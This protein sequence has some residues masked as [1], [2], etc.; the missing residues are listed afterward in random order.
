MVVDVAGLTAQN[1]HLFDYQELGLG[2]NF[3]W[4]QI[5]LVLINPDS[6]DRV[7]LSSDQMSAEI[8]V[9]DSGPIVERYIV[10]PEDEVIMETYGQ[11]QEDSVLMQVAQD[12]YVSGFVGNYGQSF[13]SGYDGTV[14][15]PNDSIDIFTITEYRYPNGDTFIYMLGTEEDAAAYEENALTRGLGLSG[16]GWDG[17]IDTVYD[18]SRAAFVSAW[19]TADGSYGSREHYF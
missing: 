9:S 17:E 4:G 16:D 15:A 14:F 2:P 7:H 19:T 18:F 10:T 8:G 12:F 5:D 3:D 6:S 13:L 11:H 1:F